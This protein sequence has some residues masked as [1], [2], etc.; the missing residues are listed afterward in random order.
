M[1][2]TWQ[3]F[4][5]CDSTLVIVALCVVSTLDAG[6]YTGHH[7]THMTRILARVEGRDNAEGHNGQSAVAPHKGQPDE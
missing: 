5:G 1:S 2:F 7:P 4:M 6:K 3:T